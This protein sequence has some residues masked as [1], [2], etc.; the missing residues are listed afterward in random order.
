M[1]AAGW[2]W[3]FKSQNSDCGQRVK[4]LSLILLLRLFVSPL[5]YEGGDNV[6]HA[7]QEAGQVLRGGVVRW[8]D[9]SHDCRRL[10]PSCF[11]AVVISQDVCQAQDPI[12]LQMKPLNDI[13]CT[14]L[15]NT[16][17]SCAVRTQRKKY[18]LRKKHMIICLCPFTY[19]LLK[20]SSFH[21]SLLLL[22]MLGNQCW[23][24]N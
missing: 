15:I 24:N 7:L 19:G 2:Y 14:D 21:S 3:V 10:S 1:V 20:G 17:C 6:V 9:L 16:S 22:W 12:H 8:G 18:F 4:S 23:T 13:G 5:T 11:H